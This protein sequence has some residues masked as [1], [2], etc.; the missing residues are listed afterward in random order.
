MRSS[1]R[2]EQSPRR[3]FVDVDDCLVLWSSEPLRTGE[4]WEPNEG[5]IALLEQH[6]ESHPD[7]LLFIWSGGGK[8]YARMW[9]ERLFLKET[10]FMPLTKDR[11][12]FPLV[13]PDSVVVDDESLRVGVPV[14]KPEEVREI[15]V[16]L[17]S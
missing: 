13:Q 12:T 1:S 4:R 16:A 11:S 14:Y 2:V 5:L 10:V 9:G 6:M 7:D 8:E 17:S 15:E 3:I